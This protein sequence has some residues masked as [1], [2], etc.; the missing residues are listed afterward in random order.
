MALTGTVAAGGSSRT[1][2]RRQRA[3]QAVDLAIGSSPARAGGV[4][5]AG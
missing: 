5:R 3:R 1:A 4:I 2:D